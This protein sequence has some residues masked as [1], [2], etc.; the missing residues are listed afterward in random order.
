[1]P[2]GRIK[3]PTA[4]TGN[5]PKGG[6]LLGLHPESGWELWAYRV[7]TSEKKKEIWVN[8]KLVHREPIRRKAN[9]WLAY[10]VT[11]LDFGRTRDYVDLEKEWPEVA[12]WAERVIIAQ[13]WTGGPAEEDMEEFL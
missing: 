10:C 3:N 7:Q 11:R 2:K 13:D 12:V 6:T 9:Y 4:R 1:M 5:P 8:L